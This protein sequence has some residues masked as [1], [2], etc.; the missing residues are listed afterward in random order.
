VELF[1]QNDFFFLYKHSLNVVEYQNMK[2]EQRLKPEFVDYLT[3]LIRLFNGCICLPQVAPTEV[4]LNNDS[5]LI[6]NC[7]A[8]DSAE[9]VPAADNEGQQRHPPVQ[10][11]ARLQIAKPT[12]LCIHV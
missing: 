11:T 4:V 6:N 7:R 1:S 10:P 5:K 12:Q 3:M 2:A 9:Q 8:L